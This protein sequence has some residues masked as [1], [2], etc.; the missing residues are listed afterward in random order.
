VCDR[1]SA[2][3]SGL[4]APF[5]YDGAVRRAI[6]RYKFKKRRECAP[7]FA[8]A[9]LD[10]VRTRLI[11]QFI[12]AVVPVPLA[13]AAYTR[14][15]FN[16]SELLAQRIGRSLKKP[17]LKNALEKCVDNP[18]QHR[19]NAAARA[20]NVL[21]VYRAG[22]QPVK[23]LRVLLIDDISTTGATLRECARVLKRTGAV[24]V[25]A[26]VIALTK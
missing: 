22:T 7:F 21:G 26:A 20:D 12:D 15:G 19:L 5:Y 24:T 17:V 16:Q 14:R 10:A 13:A 18:Q 23:K 2:G 1:Q 3:V 25:W 8:R 9:V 6:D 4:A 11:P